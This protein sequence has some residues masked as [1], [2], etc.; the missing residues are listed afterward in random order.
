MKKLFS[1]KHTERFGEDYHWSNSEQGLVREDATKIPREKW[2]AAIDRYFLIN[3]DFD[4]FVAQRGY[5][6][7]ALHH[8]WNKVVGGGNRNA[9]L[10]PAFLP[11]PTELARRKGVDISPT[12]K[13]A[14]NI[15][16]KDC[17]A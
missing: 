10:K 5:D 17:P 4:R 16:P 9:H 15:Q 14:P 6:Y 13:E 12:R 8:R 3:G 11:S 7:T 1:E 2:P